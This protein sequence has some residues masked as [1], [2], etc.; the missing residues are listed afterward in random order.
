VHKI[1]ID[2]GGTKIEGILLDEK[3]NTIQRKRV[4]THQENG[5]NSIV[6]SIISLVSELKEKTSEEITVGMCT[7]GVTNANSGLIK[8]S[9]TQCLIGMPLKNDI[10]NILGYEISMENDANCFALSESILGSAKEYDVVFG[11]IMGTG[12]GGGIVINETLHKGRTN[13]A[14][15]WGHHTLHSNG[16]ECY[17]GK[18]GCVETY[19]SGPALEKRWIEITGKKEP[20]QSI[21]QDFSDEKAKQWKEEFLENFGIGLANVID[22][23]DPD[24]IVLGGGVSNIPFLYD[25]GKEAVYD[26]VFSDSV[27]TPIL[28]NSLGD[29]AGVFGACMI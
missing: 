9:N 21:V 22:I 20:L 25:E 16:N 4:E 7:P 12:V 13:I 10:E 1:G 17:C 24:I 18:Q 11:V 19:I 2:L 23:L 26:K 5:Y 28:K 3:Y 15:E 14:G 29:S 8:N 6:K 27:D